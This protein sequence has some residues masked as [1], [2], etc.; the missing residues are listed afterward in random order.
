ML[1]I[2]EYGLYRIVFISKNPQ[3]KALQK[4]AINEVLPSIRKHSR[5]YMNEL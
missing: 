2:N 1:H 4:W 5:F 3:A